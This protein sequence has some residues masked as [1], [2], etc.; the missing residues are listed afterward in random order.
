MIAG[1]QASGLRRVALLAAL[2]ALHSAAPAAADTWPVLPYDGVVK[3]HPLINAEGTYSVE[4]I[5]GDWMLMRA[6]DARSVA[7][8]PFYLH[9]S[10]M[11]LV[12]MF[13]AL[14]MFSRRGFAAVGLSLAAA[15]PAIIA[16]FLWASR[17]DISA[18]LAVAMLALI[19]AAGM[20]LIL[21]PGRKGWIAA[22]SVALSAPALALFLYAFLGWAKVSGFSESYIE[23]LDYVLRAAREPMPSYLMILTLATLCGAIGSMCDMSADI[24]SA[25]VEMAD[26]QPGSQPPA[27]S[28]I[29]L[30]QHAVGSMTNTLLLAFAGGHATLF[31][32]WMAVH[33]EPMI[34]WNREMVAVEIVRAVGGSFGF[35]LTAVI[36]TFILKSLIFNNKI[37]GDLT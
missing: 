15:F 9:R 7:V 19:A 31:M 14:W 16:L 22:L 32:S 6:R 13:A 37:S 25:G 10:L 20:K 33:E 27:A 30:C 34:F 26:R 2:L 36:S 29:R 1:R 17:T 4:R 3:T 8:Q 28:L 35:L 18:P 11:I 12:L 24:T 23:L 21:G 5:N